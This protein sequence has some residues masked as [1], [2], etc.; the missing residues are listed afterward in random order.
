MF[1]PLEALMKSLPLSLLLI[2]LF[3]PAAYADIE[4]QQATLRT[5]LDVMDEIMNT[6]DEHIPKDLIAQAQGIIIF[7][8]M[9]KGG[10]IVAARY[11]KGVASV[12]SKKTGKWGPP[13]FLYT[14]GL[15]FGFQIGAEAVDLVLLVMTQR[16]LEGLLKD[17]F[18]L[19]GDAAVSVGPIGRHAE[20]AAD[21]L[22][23]GEIYSY[24]RSKGAFAGISIKGTVI[25][26]NKEANSEY[27]ERPL[28][29]KAIM[30]S[31]KVK[32]YPETAKRFMD[33]LNRVAPYR[34]GPPKKLP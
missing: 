22:M 6:P 34:K 23:Q 18:T 32:K 25:T 8:T 2:F 11:G 14:T 17:Q 15:S 33:G 3:I 10:F 19:G 7:P 5:A 24:S 26:A 28:S 30:I 16:G 21:I 31:E 20:A 13:A 1:A 27:Y 12:R 9:I 4:D 29:P